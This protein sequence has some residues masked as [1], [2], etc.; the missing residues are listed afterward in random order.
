MN[1]AAQ[2]VEAYSAVYTAA[3]NVDSWEGMGLPNGTQA[4]LWQALDRIKDMG[5]PAADVRSAEEISIAMHRIALALR[6][7]GPEAE[8]ETD[9]QRLELN[10][11]SR[12]WLGQLPMNLSRQA[13]I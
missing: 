10:S 1:L 3:E 7:P 12:Q 13:E 8:A 5:A 2:H 11:L 6:C 9:R 4:R